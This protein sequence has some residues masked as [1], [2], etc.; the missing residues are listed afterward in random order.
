MRIFFIVLVGLLAG[1][2]TKPCSLVVVSMPFRTAERQLVAA[3]AEAVVLQKVGADDTHVFHDYRLPD[4]ALLRVAVAKSNQSVSRLVLQRA[5][6]PSLGKTLGPSEIVTE[7]RLDDHCFKQG[8]E[9][10]PPAARSAQPS[11]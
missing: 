5:P 3:G 6:D 11:P 8:S 1:C 9:Y 7:V 10:S 2:A 4:G